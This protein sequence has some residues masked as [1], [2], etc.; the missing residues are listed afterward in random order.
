VQNGQCGIRMRSRVCWICKGYSRCRG[1][2]TYEH[3][4]VIPMQ[5]TII[6]IIKYGSLPEMSS[7]IHGSLWG[8]NIYMNRT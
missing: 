3:V 6:G 1:T 2:K 4:L 8:I 5:F 7:H